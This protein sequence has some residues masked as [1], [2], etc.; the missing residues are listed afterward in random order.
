L[1]AV[2]VRERSC[3]EIAQELER[4]IDVL[5]TSQRDVP[6]RHRSLRAVFDQSWDLLG[7]DEQRVL[8]RVSVF[9]GGFD[10][11]AATEVAQANRALLISLVQR[12]LLRQSPAGRFEMH[13]LLRQYAEERLA[14]STAEKAQ[15]VARHA[16]YFMELAE[17]SFTELVGPQQV[18]WSNRIER[19]HNNLRAALARSME[20][21]SELSKTDVALR[22]AVGLQR[23][24]YF[25]GY[26]AEGRRW[27]APVLELPAPEVESVAGVAMRGP[28]PHDFLRAKALNAI[29][30]LSR[31][32][33]DYEAAMLAVE[34]SVELLRTLGYQHMLAGPLNNLGLNARD[35]GDYARA[36]ALMTEA[37]Q[38]NREKGNPQDMA[39]QLNNLG[40]LALMRGNLGKARNLLEESLAIFRDLKEG[41]GTALALTNLGQVARNEG[42]YP[43]AIASFVE[44]LALYRDVGDRRGITDCLEGLAVA[45]A[46]GDNPALLA[47]AATIYGSAAALREATGAH[48]HPSDQEYLDR[49]VSSLRERLGDAAWEVSQAQGRAMTAEQ[50]TSFALNR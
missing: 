26:L 18:E 17:T 7:E 31:E 34:E 30:I 4:S 32:Q 1:A 47:H 41:R 35:L 40:K 19:E 6:A 13:D 11:E 39:L 50:A 22:M 5:A 46:A 44:S 45:Y 38:L 16:R 24:W 20:A 3:Q 28:D 37:L 49:A 43:Q 10:L 14:K 9:V 21:G 12:S 15:V 42:D 48:M 25:R 36:E 2:L 29:S 33:G 23:F 27:F 8:R